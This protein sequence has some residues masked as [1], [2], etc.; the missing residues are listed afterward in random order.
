MLSM[1]PNLGNLGDRRQGNGGI[2]AWYGLDRAES[3]QVSLRPNQLKHLFSFLPT[4]PCVC[5]YFA[6]RHMSDIREYCNIYRTRDEHANLPTSRTDRSKALKSVEERIL[7]PKD[8]IL[9]KK[10]ERSSAF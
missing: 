5:K 1:C 3:V 2:P 4:L 7:A 10:Q 8:T 9:C 6:L